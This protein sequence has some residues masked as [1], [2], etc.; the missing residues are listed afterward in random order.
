M[1][2]PDS[3]IAASF[4]LR[5]ENIDSLLAIDHMTGRSRIPVAGNVSLIV[6]GGDDHRI[7]AE[8]VGGNVDD[9]ARR[10]YPCMAFPAI[11]SKEAKSA[12]L[13]SFVR[14]PRHTCLPFGFQPL[15]PQDGHKKEAGAAAGVPRSNSRLLQ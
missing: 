1:T 3:E 2:P 14:K 4:P 11:A 15:M 5:P 12:E 9:P 13:R 10:L 6:N 8:L 7:R